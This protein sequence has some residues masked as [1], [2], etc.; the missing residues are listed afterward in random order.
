M[1]VTFPYHSTLSHVLNNGEDRPD[2]TGTGVRSVFGVQNK[3]DLRDG[4]PLVT[5]KRV[6]WHAVV[7]ELLWF[8]GGNTQVQ[9]LQERNVRIWD[10]WAPDSGY[11]GPIYGAQ[12][13]GGK[14]QLASLIKGIKDDPHGRRHIVDSWNPDDLSEMA[15]PPCHMMFQCY[16]SKDGDLDLL[17]HQRSADLFLGVPFN[18]ASY[19]LLMQIIGHLT[20]LSPRHFIHNMGDAH[21]YHNHLNQVREQLSRTERAAPTVKWS[22][23]AMRAR[24]LNDFALGHMES[25]DFKLE[26]YNPHPTIKGKVAV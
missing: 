20:G 13:R 16:V 5:T 23:R 9:P 7:T 6:Y 19:A 21:I 1:G 10:A 8:I 22:D 25:S 11:L 2:R 18:V 3:Y 14:D 15:L 12:W 26:G 4:F 17:L 24:T